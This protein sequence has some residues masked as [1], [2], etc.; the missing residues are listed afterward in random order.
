[1]Q[2][3]L[4]LCTEFGLVIGNTLFEEPDKYKVTWMHR[5]S[6]NWHMLDYVIVRKRDRQ[7]LC[8]VRVCRSAECWTD[9]RLVRAKFCVRVR[10]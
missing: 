4:K 1:M 6:K 3:L 7:D 2:L 9:H 5:R 10:P 8:L